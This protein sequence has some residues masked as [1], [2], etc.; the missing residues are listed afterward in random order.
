MPVLADLLP[1]EQ[2]RSPAQLG[3]LSRQVAPA[4]GTGGSSALW[5][6]SH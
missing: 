1:P 3:F 4:S 2:E 5:P 6:A